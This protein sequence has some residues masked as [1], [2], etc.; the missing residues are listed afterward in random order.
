MEIVQEELGG[1]VS[2]DDISS[3][4]HSIFDRESDEEGD[5]EYSRDLSDFEG[6]DVGE[7][8]QSHTFTMPPARH[9][10]GGVVEVDVR[11]RQTLTIERYEKLE[12]N[13][14]YVELCFLP[15]DVELEKHCNETLLAGKDVLTEQETKLCQDMLRS[16]V[17]AGE[18]NVMQ[19]L[20]VKPFLCLPTGLDKK[21]SYST[22]GLPLDFERLNHLPQRDRLTAAVPDA[23]WSFHHKTAFDEGEVGII[24]KFYREW[25]RAS[26]DRTAL[27]M[28]VAYEAKA[29]GTHGNPFRAE[30]QLALDLCVARTLIAKLYEEAKEVSN[31]RQIPCMF[32]FTEKDVACFGFTIQNDMVTYW[33]FHKTG[34]PTKTFA[35]SKIGVWPIGI[36]NKMREFWAI[37]NALQSW[38][39]EIR[40]PKIKEALKIIGDG[41][42]A[43]INQ[44]RESSTS[45]RLKASA[46]SV[47][48]GE[49]P[50][51][52][53]TSER[54]AAETNVQ[55]SGMQEGERDDKRKRSEAEREED[56]TP[57]KRTRRAI[58]ASND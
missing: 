41:G 49:D 31:R 33:A 6:I 26:T 32:D 34:A 47:Q 12:E 2:S 9:P 21:I 37:Q 4:G 35:M 25:A 3:L 16:A 45:E 38:A 24:N 17:F 40:L 39:L 57:N 23:I 36:P 48:R 55:Q 53:A 58:C 27:W 18:G 43:I 51:D 42:E 15:E 13:G 29:S 44:I 30:N 52:P 20:N 50:T 56:S 46:D 19:A 1:R 11:S 14:I 22:G 54:P 10:L 8:N 5:E 28:M 7:W